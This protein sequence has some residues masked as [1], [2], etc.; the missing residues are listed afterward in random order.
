VYI[1]NVAIL[2]E[3][4]AEIEHFFSDRTLYSTE[5]NISDLTT[6]NPHMHKTYVFQDQT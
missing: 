4:A 6:I 3:M 1:P 5:Q 2:R